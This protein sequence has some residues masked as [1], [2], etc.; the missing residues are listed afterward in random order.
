[1]R[2]LPWGT[3]LVIAIACILIARFSKGES[4]TIYGAVAALFLGLGYVWN[5]KG[6]AES[7]L[8][9]AEAGHKQAQR[10]RQI[11]KLHP[12]TFNVLEELSGDEDSRFGD[13]DARWKVKEFLERVPD[14]GRVPPQ[15][16]LQKCKRNRG[17]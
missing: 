4:G 6:S 13:E 3:G 8:E 15:F 16:R 2:R 11:R 7:A 9:Q 1:M 12:E 10:D 5:A 17:T 14:E